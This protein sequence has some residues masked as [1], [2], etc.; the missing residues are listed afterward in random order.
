M[1]P[2][3]TLD[4]P[5]SKVAGVRCLNVNW[6]GTACTRWVMVLVKD[7]EVLVREKRVLEG[8]ACNQ[9]W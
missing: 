8:A 4:E 5:L 3:E 7:L 1:K 9:L 6:F 2:S